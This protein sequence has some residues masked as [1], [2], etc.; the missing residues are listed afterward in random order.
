MTDRTRRQFL[1]GAGIASLIG[2]GAGL[3]LVRPAQALA[4]TWPGAVFRNKQVDPVLRAL[5]G[6]TPAHPSAGVVLGVPD[7]A[8]NG[9]VVPV[10][11]RTHL[12]GVTEMALIVDHNP[13]PLVGVLHLT[14][15]AEGFLKTRIKMN[16]TSPVRAYVRTNHGLYFTTHTVKVTVGG[17]GG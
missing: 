3:G 12:P 14:S 6:D 7:L 2:L 13:F 1:R 15:G 5:F 9:A 8:E 10:S 11:L 17:C 4:R 16:K